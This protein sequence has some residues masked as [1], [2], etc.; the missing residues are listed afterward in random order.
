MAVSLNKGQGISLKKSENNLIAL[1]ISIIIYKLLR[2]SN[3][4]CVGERL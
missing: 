2:K 3:S 1:S 4:L